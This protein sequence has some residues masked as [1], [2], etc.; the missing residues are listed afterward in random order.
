MDI[1]AA[2]L[3][4]DRMYRILTSTVMPRPIA[5]VSTLNA[6]GG[7]NAAP[8]SFFNVFSEAP[9]LLILGVEGSQRGGVPAPK[10]TSRNIAERKEFVVNLVSQALAE[11]MVACAIPFPEGVSELEEAGLTPR[12]SRQIATPGIAESPVSFECRLFANQTLPQGR[13]LITGEIV[14][15]HLPDGLLDDKG[16]V[17]AGALDLIGRMSGN[18][19]YCATRERFQIPAMTAAAWRAKRGT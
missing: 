12:P 16:F 18:G 14:H 4:P 19:W 5:L 11:R 15:L 3:A 7:V 6:G 8:F 9:P 17:D 2:D 1:A 10:D 13:N